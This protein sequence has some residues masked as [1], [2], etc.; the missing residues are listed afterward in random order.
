ME[1]SLDNLSHEE[2]A[3]AQSI[4]DLILKYSQAVV[5][6]THGEKLLAMYLAGIDR[7]YPYSES[8]GDATEW[9]VAQWNRLISNPYNY[10]ATSDFN[11]DLSQLKFDCSATLSGW[12]VRQF[13][14]FFDHLFHDM[15]EMYMLAMMRNNRRVLSSQMQ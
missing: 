2:R 4:L 7:S 8:N 3:V 5:H 11:R 1:Y 14:L 9:A 15:G 13:Q 6:P 10:Y 12:R